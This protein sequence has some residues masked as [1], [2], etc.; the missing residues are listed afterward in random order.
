[1]EN[2]KIQKSFGK[3]IK[4]IRQEKGISQEYLAELV[5]LHRTYISDI[6]RGGRNVS[7][8][9]IWRIA[10]GLEVSAFEIFKEMEKEFEGR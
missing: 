8:V 6:E 1:M 2:I 9:N 7:L 3:V 5:D 4:K 10:E